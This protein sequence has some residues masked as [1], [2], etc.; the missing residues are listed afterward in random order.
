[1]AKEAKGRAKGGIARRDAMSEVERRESAQKAAN[2]RWNSELPIASHEGDFDLGDT[3]VSCAVLPNGGRI[4][5]QATFLRALGRS[6]SPKAG[7]GVLTTADDLPFFLQADVLK[8]FIS[9]DLVQ[10]TAPIFY[11]TQKGGKGV[12]YDA[13]LLPQVADVYLKFRDASIAQTGS[14]PARYE[15]IVRAADLLVRALANV[16]IIALID[17]ATG[18]QEVRD[19]L[20]LQAVLDAFLRKELAAW[21]K[22]FPDEFYFQIYRLRGWKWEGRGKNPPQVVA[23]Y[24]KDFVYA[25]LA[26]SILEEIEKRNPIENGRRKSKHHQWLTDDVGHP[27][28]AQHLHAVITLMRVSKTWQQF[29][30]MLNVAHPKRNDTLQLPLMADATVPVE[31]EEASGQMNMLLEPKSENEEAA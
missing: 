22:R 29:K 20:A 24:T 3:Q 6:R 8:P 27:A 12:G 9:D 30:D 26:P 31:P 18:Y 10:S 2:A 5:T 28:L 4:I 19:R 25:R 16:G 23:S 21:A 15:H 13:R 7:T 11:R 14:V 17:E 1:M